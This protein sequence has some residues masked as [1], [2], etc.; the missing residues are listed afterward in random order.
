MFDNIIYFWLFFFSTRETDTKIN[1][2]TQ[3]KH[4]IFVNNVGWDRIKKEH[5]HNKNGTKKNG[6]NVYGWLY[7]T[8]LSIWEIKIERIISWMLT[9][10]ICQS[11]RSTSH[12]Y[13]P[14]PH[15]IMLPSLDT[16]LVFLFTSWSSSLN[17]SHLW[18]CSAATVKNE[19]DKK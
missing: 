17:D 4:E 14:M 3:F 11:I 12:E 8:K 6:T 13:L 9:R 15:Y 16:Y 2:A 5:T 10:Y 19:T 18:C 1:N 7:L